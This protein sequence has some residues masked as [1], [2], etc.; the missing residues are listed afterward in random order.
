MLSFFS[1]LGVVFHYKFE[2]GGVGLDNTQKSVSTLVGFRV[3][4][5]TDQ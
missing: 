4:C 5:I 2:R 1:V 3:E